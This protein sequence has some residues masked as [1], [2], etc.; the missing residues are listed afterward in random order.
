M[1]EEDLRLIRLSSEALA[2]RVRILG[3]A[4]RAR[5]DRRVTSW[6]YGVAFASL[7]LMVATSILG[8]SAEIN[9]AIV[10]DPE[11]RPT[12]QWELEHL[13]RVP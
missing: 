1:I 13:R 8:W 4:G 7:A 10:A 6:I 12:S 11:L 2:V 3:A 5:R 9:P